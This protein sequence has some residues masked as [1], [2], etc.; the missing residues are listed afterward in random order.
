MSTLE[1]TTALQR[2]DLLAPPVAD[3]IA[4][5]P[6]EHLERVLVAPIDPDLAD[7][8]AFCAAYDVAPEASANCLVVM[9]KRGDVVTTAAVLVLATT[10]ADV[11]GVVRH[12]L[13]ARKASF[14]STDDATERTG[15]EYGGIT[16][17]GVPSDW[18]VFVDSRIVDL[19]EVIVGAGIRGAKIALPGAVLAALPGVEVIDGLARPVA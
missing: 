11:N 1:L 17:I 2:P 16:P 4:A 12:L 13:D 7:T 19:P 3:A 10:R 18:R 15:M 6:P 8:A 5:L 14:A 9:G